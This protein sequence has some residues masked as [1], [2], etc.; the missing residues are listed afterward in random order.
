[1]GVSRATA[2][3]WVN[4]YRRFGELGR[5]DRSSAPR[6]QPTATPGDIVAR[7]EAATFIFTQQSTGTRGWPTRKR[8]QM[9]ERRPPSSFLPVPERGSLPM[10][11]PISNGS[12]RTTGLATVRHAL[13]LRSK[14]HD[15][16]GLRRTRRD[17]TGKSK[18]ITA[19]SPKS[20]STPAPG[21][22]NRSEPLH[23]KSGTVMTTITGPTARMADNPQLPRRLYTST[24][25]WPHTP[26][27]SARRICGP[28]I[29][30]SVVAPR[31][32]ADC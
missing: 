3:K 28:W 32:V 24:T 30:R 4:R 31:S 22:Q 15:T 18:D 21:T 11:S 8:Y 12:S 13:L 5:R 10:A 17:T 7:I 26:S 25:S 6:R 29:S 2:S 20:S 16:S 14:T 1:M 27:R 19:S 23:S 9:N